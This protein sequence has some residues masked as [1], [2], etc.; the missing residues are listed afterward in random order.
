MLNKRVTIELDISSQSTNDELEDLFNNAVKPFVY[1]LPIDEV[2]DINIGDIIV[3]DVE[4]HNGL[5]D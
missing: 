2:D 3:R 5:D 4:R 1:N